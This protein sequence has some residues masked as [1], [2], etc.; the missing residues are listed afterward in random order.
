MSFYRSFVHGRQES[1]T[2]ESWKRPNV[3]LSPKIMWY[4]VGLD[5]YRGRCDVQM[6]YQELQSGFVGSLM[7]PLLPTKCF[8]LP[9]QASVS[10][11]NACH[12]W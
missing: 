12:P 10:I 1:W 2:I 6:L 11:N 9:P 4:K 7:P 5:G 3:G 8:S